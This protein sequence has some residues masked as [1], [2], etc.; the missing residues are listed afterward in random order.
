MRQIRTGKSVD[1]RLVSLVFFFCVTFLLQDDRKLPQI[2]KGQ[3]HWFGFIC[4]F[5]HSLVNRQSLR[6]PVDG[7]GGAESRTL[8]VRMCCQ[9]HVLP[10]TSL[11][12]SFLLHAVCA[13]TFLFLS[14]AC[15]SNN[16]TN[17]PEVSLGSI[18]R[19][20]FCLPFHGLLFHSRTRQ[21][22]LRQVCMVHLIVAITGAHRA[23]DLPLAAA[24]A[25]W[26]CRSGSRSWMCQY[27]TSWRKSWRLLLVRSSA[28]VAQ[29]SGDS[30]GDVH[31]LSRSWMFRYH[32]SW[33]SMLT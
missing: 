9:S 7:C 18:H 19:L 27:H 13:K 1:R 17:S 26:G 12:R 31:M 22:V 2:E 20:C 30:T 14:F 6:L 3:S 10:A 32:G 23:P 33:S 15:V 11:A 16:Q 24:V 4:F 21:F 29:A 25:L 5:F 28:T 8:Q